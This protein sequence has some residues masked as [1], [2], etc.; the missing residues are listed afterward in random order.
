MRRRE[1]IQMAV[2]EFWATMGV[3]RPS[4]I[5]AVAAQAEA[6]G[7]DGFKI[8]DTQCLVGEAFVFAT[9][10]ATATR[11]INLSFSTS[12]PATRHPSVAASA[13]AALAEIAGRP[14]WFGVGRGDS[15]LAYVGGAPA[16]IEM[17]ERFIRAVRAYLSGEAVPFDLI[18]PWRLTADV[19]TIRLG[20]APEASSLTWLDPARPRAPIEVYATGPKAIGVAGR[21]GDRVALGL[22]GDVARLRWAMDLAREARAEAG[23]DPASLSFTAVVPTCV[24][25]DHA[26]TRHA[27]AN[28]VASSARFSVISGKLVG[29]ATAAQRQ[30]Y[31]AIGQRYDMTHHGGF[32]DQVNALTDA[33]I[34]DYAIVGPPT[35]C[36]ERIH[37]L[38]EIGIDA[39][40]L[41]APPVESTTREM[42]QSYD[43]LVGEVLPRARTALR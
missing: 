1:D 40:M 4:E 15:A 17:F 41:G 6:D 20:H 26:R 30:V 43:L 12:N 27:I 3:V 16:S 8:F 10:A 34:D 9:A 36:V 22:G 23:L 28:L 32:G 37:Q 31:E 38:A 11:R 39:I 35:A 18:A 25:H 14:V 29:P 19:S 13:T 5:A 2:P 42:R 33:F 21:C 7:W 24:G